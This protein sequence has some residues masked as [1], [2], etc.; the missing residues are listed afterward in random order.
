MFYVRSLKVFHQNLKFS[1]NTMTCRKW[2]HHNSLPSESLIKDF[3]DSG[4]VLELCMPA[5]TVS[6]ALTVIS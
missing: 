3:Q 4:F 1:E 6:T 5:S 2:W